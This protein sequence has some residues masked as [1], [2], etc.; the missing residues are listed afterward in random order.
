MLPDLTNSVVPIKSGETVQAVMC[1]LLERRGL[2]Y[3]TYEVYLHK[4]DK[5]RGAGRV[6][7]GERGWE[8]LKKSV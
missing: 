4:T 2:T 5:V 7:E 1:R 3:S 6:G 8:R